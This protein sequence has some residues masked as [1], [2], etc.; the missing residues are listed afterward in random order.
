ME[1]EKL[2]SENPNSTSV[3]DWYNPNIAYGNEYYI[4]NGD[5]YKQLTEDQQHDLTKNIV[6]TMS[7]I[8]GPEKEMTVNLQL[9]HWFRIDISL[10]IAV[11]KGLDIDL[12][13]AMKNMPTGF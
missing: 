11:A 3:A 9:C 10:G 5:I 7:N 6:H 1:N 2:P 13:E 12:G 8:T 4:R